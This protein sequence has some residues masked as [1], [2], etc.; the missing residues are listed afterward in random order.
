[1]WVARRRWWMLTVWVA[2]L[3]GSAVLYPHL[4]S[5]L[6]PSDYSVTGSDSDKVTNLI[7]TDFSSAGAEQDVIVFDS[8]SLTIR[9][10]AY[11]K[12]VD[13][14]LA[15]VEDEPGVVSTLSPTDPVAEGQVSE[16]GHAAIATL[17]LNGSDQERSDRA[18][19]LQKV[20]E[21]ATAVGQ[22]E[23]NLTGYSPSAND[24]TEVENADVERAESVGIP[25]AFIVLL[26]AL[27]ALVAASV[28]LLTALVS[29]TATLGLI[30][31]LMAFTAFEADAFMLS[32]VTMIGVGVSIDYSLFILTRFR[33]EL[34]LARDAGRPDPVVSAVGTAMTTS[35]RTIAFS[36]AIVVVSMC[37]LL[38][39]NSPL[40]RAI[41]A[42][43]VLVVLCTLVTAWTMLPALLAALGERVNKGSLPK[44]FRPAETEEGGSDRPSFW[45]RWARTVI[46]HPWLAIPAAALLL[47]FATPALGIEVG[48]DLGLA[49]ISDTPSGK[50]EV[51]LDEEFS[52]GA[53]S[54]IQIL[55]SHDGSGALTP[56]DLSAIDDL[57]RDLAKDPRVTDAYSIS[58][59]L[60]DTTGDVSPQA[61]AARTRQK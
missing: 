35:G 37:S 48:L 55:V 10:A 20:I 61:L 41:T 54:P 43:A 56:K 24:L 9:D 29:L 53:M 4:M 15:A 44:R 27:A 19:S 32:I 18:K 46:R 25:V 5:S 16:D 22:V 42:G 33:E 38:V 59:L 6:V 30:S 50:A 1:M 36:G 2:L 51:I 12:V 28:P 40:F 34:V 23:A 7:E 8:G 3:I 39:V 11:V 13:R 45:A 14:V 17:G 26:L 47:L 58:V 57:T 21:S 49:A 52:P 31:L 60:R